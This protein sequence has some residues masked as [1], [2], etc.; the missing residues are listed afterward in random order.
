MS[1]PVG[2]KWFQPYESPKAFV[3][4]LKGVTPEI[5][6]KVRWQLMEA[7]VTRKDAILPDFLRGF[8]DVFGGLYELLRC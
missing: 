5:R 8:Q 1:V 4:M 6:E 2:D 7:S 3:L